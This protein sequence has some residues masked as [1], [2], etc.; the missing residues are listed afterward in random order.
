VLLSAISLADS[1]FCSQPPKL[2]AITLL[3]VRL[4]SPAGFLIG[5][6]TCRSLGAHLQYFVF[7]L[8]SI[9]FAS[10]QCRR[11]PV[12]RSSSIR[13][14]TRFFSGNFPH[15]TGRRIKCSVANSDFSCGLPFPKPPPWPVSCRP[16]TATAV[17][18]SSVFRLPLC[19]RCLPLPRN[20]PPA[21]DY[22]PGL[23]EVVF[24]VFP[25]VL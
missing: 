5:S 7:L 17:L 22:H 23:R 21:S 16:H 13:T 9:F 6:R 1:F 20:I 11:S 4:P 10:R 2:T 15:S 14:L 19:R 24:S 8:S 18:P 12:G 25:G 3:S